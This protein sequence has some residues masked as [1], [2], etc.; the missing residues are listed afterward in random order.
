MGSIDRIHVGANYLRTGKRA[1]YWDLRER[2][3]LICS[4]Q[5]MV[6]ER[7]CKSGRRGNCTHTCAQFV[8]KICREDF[9]WD[10]EA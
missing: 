5:E 2:R 8:F 3:V 4:L 9:I 6:R 7:C 10:A 1:E